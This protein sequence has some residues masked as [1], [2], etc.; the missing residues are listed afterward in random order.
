MVGYPKVAIAK[1]GLSRVLL[2]L[3]FPLTVVGQISVQASPPRGPVPKYYFGLHIH[4]LWQD[5]EWPSVPFGT[6]RLWDSHTMWAYLEPHPGQYDFSLLDKYADVAQA[7][8]VELVLTLAGTPAWASKRPTEVPEHEGGVKGAPGLA[9]EPSTIAP[10]EDFV[11]TVATRYKGRIH[12]YEIWNEPMSRP[13]FSG[14]PQDLAAM[15]QSAATIL[16]QVDPANKVLSPPVSGDDKGLSWF[17][18][19][20]RAGGG[21]AVDIYGFHFYVGGPPEKMLP[22]IEAAR[23]LLRKYSQDSKPMWN[24]EAGW[25][26]AQLGQ[27]TSATYVARALLI[28]WP[29]GLNRYL[30]YSWDHPQFGIAPSGQASTAMVRA[31]GTVEHW[32]EGAV[33]TRCVGTPSGLWVENLTLKNGSQAKVVW[34]TGSPTPLTSEN[35][36]EAKFSTTLDGQTAPIQASSLPEANDSPILLSSDGRVD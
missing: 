9:A 24:T 23:S 22:K 1:L 6:W 15:V 26:T 17:D 29:F 31:Y 16:K 3:L 25:Q 35:V 27:R 14:Q 7:H 33:V 34:S 28:A 32:L 5:T 30:L 19:F 11:R 2:L 18:G 21:Q 4:H 12:Y 10:W 8:Q 13:F 36:G 20:L